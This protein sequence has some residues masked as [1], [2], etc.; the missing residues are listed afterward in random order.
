VA[1]F[2]AD[3]LCGRRSGIAVRDEILRVGSLGRAARVWA[4]V[5]ELGRALGLLGGAMVEG[6][7]SPREFILQV[8]RCSS[9]VGRE[10]VIVQ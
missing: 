10:L 2:L 8:F 3:V 9:R 1:D 5:R 7:P 4:Y 6:A